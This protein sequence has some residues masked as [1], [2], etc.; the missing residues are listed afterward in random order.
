MGS[1]DESQGNREW[2]ETRF[3]RDMTRFYE[4]G[5]RK[6]LQTKPTM[7]TAGGSIKVAKMGSMAGSMNLGSFYDS[8]TSSPRASTKK[9]AR[10]KSAGNQGGKR[11][12]KQGTAN[13]SVHIPE[14]N[15]LANT[16]FEL[17]PVPEQQSEQFGISY[18]CFYPRGFL[19]YIFYISNHW[20]GRHTRRL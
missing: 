14:F 8:P 13:S 9:L 10:G 1:D 20:Y 12:A 18:T 6:R 15:E 16:N 4:A 2:Y 3:Y 7:M 17:P 11:I 19:L 5:E